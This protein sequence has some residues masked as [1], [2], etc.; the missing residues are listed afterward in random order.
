MTILVIDDHH[1]V[2]V[3][4]VTAL[5]GKSLD[6]HRC[7]V[8]DVEGVLDE[9]DRHAPGLAL[10][11]L[12]LG[13][14]PDGDPRNGVDLV[15]PLNRSGWPIVVVSGSTRTERIAEAVAAG[16]SGWVPKSEDFDGLLAAVLAAAEGK[17]LLTTEQRR[18][19]VALHRA[20]SR[21]V[22]D[23]EGRLSRLSNRESEV[24]ERLARGRRA[25]AIAE[26]FVISLATVRTQIRSIL[27]KLD[28]GSQLEAVALHQ[29]ARR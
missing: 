2:A 23:V 9:A 6:A 11:D 12:D 25:A 19:W 1:L 13:R 27:T 14:T 18:E 5:R 29:D 22:A 7:P 21:R 28:V 16:A 26:E 20:E 8:L 10:V 15:G 24:L 4:L 17:P 3:S